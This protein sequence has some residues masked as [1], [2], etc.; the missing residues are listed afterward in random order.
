MAYTH[1]LLQMQAWCDAHAMRERADSIVVARYVPG[2]EP[3]A[4]KA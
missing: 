1:T 4:G 2:S 3:E